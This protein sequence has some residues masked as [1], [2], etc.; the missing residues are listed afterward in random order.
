[1]KL[2]KAFEESLGAQVAGKINQLKEPLIALG[3]QGLIPILDSTLELTDEFLKWFETLDEGTIKAMAKFGLFAI[4]LTPLLK[5][6]SSLAS[7]GSGLLIFFLYW[8]VKYQV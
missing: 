7:A 8:V 5:L 6:F 4:V 1:M 2:R 3:E